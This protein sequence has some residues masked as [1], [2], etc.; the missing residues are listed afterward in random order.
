MDE[1]WAETESGVYVMQT[2]QLNRAKVGLDDV[3]EGGGRVSEVEVLSLGH[4]IFKRA[5]YW[6]SSWKFQKAL[7]A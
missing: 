6:H 2:P 4:R 1:Y 7:A 3:I 5:A